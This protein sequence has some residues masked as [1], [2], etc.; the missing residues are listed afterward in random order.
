MNLVANQFK[1]KMRLHLTPLR[2]FAH[3]VDVPV[4]RL[5]RLQLADKRDSNA[6]KTF[7]AEHARTFLSANF[8]LVYAD[9]MQ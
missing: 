6:T 8:T 3:L 7:K 4:E 2:H 9:L 5:R 1:L